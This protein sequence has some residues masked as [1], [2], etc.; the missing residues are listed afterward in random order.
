[1]T[2]LRN[3]LERNRAIGK[4]RAVNLAVAGRLRQRR[5][6][7]YSLLIIALAALGMA[8]ILVRTA[9]H[10]AAVESTA[11]TYMSIAANLA[12]GEG[13]QDFRGYRLLPWPP[14]FPALMAV[15]GLVGIEPADAGRLL[16]AAAFG[17]I[18][19]VSGLW[20]R[21][22]LRSPFL[23]V[24][25]TLIIMVPAPFAPGHFSS[26]IESEPLFMLFSL[27]ALMWIVPFLSRGSLWRPILLAAVFSA[28]A[29][30]T[31]YAG[32][33]LIFT[34]VLLLLLRR[35]SSLVVRLKYATVY[36][37]IASIPLATVLAYNQV[38]FGVPLRHTLRWD[39]P[40]RP[41]YHSL[42]RIVDLF[43][44]GALPV[45]SPDWYPYL[46]WIATGLVIMGVAAVC[47][48]YRSQLS[49]KKSGSLQPLLPFVVFALPYLTL[50]VVAASYRPGNDPITPRLLV[51]LYVP[52]LLAGACLL[53]RLLHLRAAGW[54]ARVKW[55]AVALILTG[56]LG[57][58][59]VWTASGIAATAR[60]LESGY[61]NRT[62]NTAHWDGSATIEYLR[63]N[64][65]DTRIYCN[66]FGILHFLL[67][68]DAG[69]NVRG[70]YPQLARDVP[71]VIRQINDSGDG[72]HIVWLYD[73][74]RPYYNYGV[75][76]LRA[77]P[78]LEVVA[79][80]DD[81]VIF[82]FTKGNQANRQYIIP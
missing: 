72:T 23:A 2:R 73:D 19:L 74:V 77:L 14:L 32:V 70:K 50:I 57:S 54:M 80:L 51:P 12:A 78:S 34:G 71:D 67:A 64:P 68:L 22:T 7:G 3:Q 61:H 15:F 21:R 56:C 49:P 65:V 63:A 69:I 26:G 40:S 13:W 55:V 81:G 39:D 24:G 62:Y 10:G 75:A 5:P 53:D 4:L 48:R 31:R 37:I 20:L 1:M 46:L 16:N 30:V 66:R 8:H 44:K 82:K 58:A 35:E 25:A 76:D 38:L 9:T 43:P 42:N 28:L 41:L 33:P 60:A 27:L 36:G 79:E 11:V 45:N 47:I 52:L 6:D 17:L 29:A 59:S 18:I